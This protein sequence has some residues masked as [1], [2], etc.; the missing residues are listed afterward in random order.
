ME[1]HYSGI[2]LTY[3]ALNRVLHNNSMKETFDT[4]HDCDLTIRKKLLYWYKWGKITQKE[5]QHT[6]SCFYC[7]RMAY[8][9][10][11]FNGFIWSKFF[12][13]TLKIHLAIYQDIQQL[14]APLGKINPFSE[15]ELTSLPANSAELQKYL[16]PYTWTQQCP[17]YS[18]ARGD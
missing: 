13:F 5:A 16:N 15:S 11:L 18:W 8:G 17:S 2:N 10:T 4:D 1:K 12:Y 14:K 3:T 6:P 7:K 9:P